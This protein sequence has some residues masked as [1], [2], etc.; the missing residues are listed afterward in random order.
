MALAYIRSLVIIATQW[1]LDRYLSGVE[2]PLCHTAD[3]VNHD[4]L[5]V[6]QA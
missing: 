6:G 1:E 4:K 2:N 5:T 3:A